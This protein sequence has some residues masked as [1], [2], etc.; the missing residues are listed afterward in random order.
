MNSFFNFTGL[1][2]VPYTFAVLSLPPLRK[3]KLQEDGSVFGSS[4]I[5]KS[6]EG[7]CHTEDKH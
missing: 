5:S 2:N 6:G 3:F 4:H 1:Q 7:N